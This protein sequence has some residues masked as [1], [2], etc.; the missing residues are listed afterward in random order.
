MTQVTEIRRPRA[1]ADEANA[2]MAEMRERLE[3]E[4]EQV[5]A[6]LAVRVPRGPDS[7]ESRRVA[8]DPQMVRRHLRLLGQLIA[9]LATVDLRTVWDD[10]AGFGSTVFL[11]DLDSGEDAFY[12]LMVGDLIDLDAAQVSLESPLG[13]ALLGGRAGDQP[14][15][16]T[17]HGR[18]RFRVLAVHTLP[19]SLGMT[20]P[21]TP[22]AA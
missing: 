8:T 20:E 9:G 17:P 7:A 5:S 13:Q 12:T 15:V 10:R 21:V 3:S 22:G 6:E 2:R 18:R 1:A 14:V 16:E 4:L 19:Q 11:R